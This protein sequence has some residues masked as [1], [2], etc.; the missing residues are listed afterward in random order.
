MTV[1]LINLALL[2][3][4][5]ALLLG[6]EPDKLKRKVYC[7]VA[8]LQWVLLSGLRHVSVGADTLAYK[9][10]SF[11]PL[12]STPWRDVISRAVG[13]IF[14]PLNIKDPGYPVVVKALQLLTQ[15][16]Q[17]F[18]ILV[19]LIFMVPL[20]VLIY[21]HSADPMMSF[22]IFSC[23][24]SSFFAVTGIRQTIAT[25]LI[26]LIG[27]EFARQRRLVLFVLVALAAFTIHKSSLV[28]VPFY[29][30][31]GIR[32]TWNRLIGILAL[33]PAVYV[34]RQ[35]LLTFFGGMLGYGQYTDQYSG[36]GAWVF[37]AML[38]VVALVALW[39]APLVLDTEPDA[40][41]WYFATLVAFTLTP[42][43]FVDPNL[44]RIAQYYSAFLM[45]L[46]PSVLRSFHDK[47]ERALAYVV[48][49]SLIIFLY[50][51]T[52]PQYLFFWQAL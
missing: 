11:D 42:L 19:A 5:A 24:F 50:V 37:S 39:R 40:T 2:I 46:V 3:L 10:Y 43:T 13:A 29:F 7:A 38:F 27:Y 26:V 34:F 35:P 49:V 17:V 6:H 32:P 15:D 4:W 51:R 20:G 16:Y 9:L 41:P 44:M 23:L 36:A 30:F 45:L 21:R 8:T 28:F 47:N 52:N 48:A 12:L 14:G 25:A 22:L 18:L 33:T 31:F 1:Y